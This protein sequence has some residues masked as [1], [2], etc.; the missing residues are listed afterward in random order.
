MM[1]GVLLSGVIE[2]LPKDSD[3]AVRYE[4]ICAVFGCD[5]VFPQTCEACH[6]GVCFPRTEDLPSGMEDKPV[7]LFLSEVT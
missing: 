3:G 4:D 1:S 2:R 6:D 5:A 7:R